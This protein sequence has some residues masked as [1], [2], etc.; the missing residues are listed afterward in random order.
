MDFRK[1]LRKKLIA[2]NVLNY[3]YA[4]CT[5]YGEYSDFSTLV[6]TVE[7][8]EGTMVSPSFE[9]MLH[10]D[11]MGKIIKIMRL[12]KI[13][14]AGYLIN[15]FSDEIDKKAEL[16]LKDILDLNRVSEAWSLT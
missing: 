6:I 12:K 5:D 13:Y 8:N 3:D 15:K 16:I 1:Y 11:Q 9:I 10:M 14:G 4:Y 7:K 2:E